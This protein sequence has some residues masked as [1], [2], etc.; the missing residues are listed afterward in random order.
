MK[1]HFL[2]ALMVFSGVAL[3]ARAQIGGLVNQVEDNQTRNELNR[4]ASQAGGTN[5]VPDLYEGE[6]GDVGPQSVVQR[7]ARHTLFE[8]EADAQFFYTDNILLTKQRKQGTGVLLS[9]AQ[10]ALAPTPYA[11]G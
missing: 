5:A 8:A 1:K 9:T 2:Y 10:F 6:S 4:S 3:S 7:Q 11:V